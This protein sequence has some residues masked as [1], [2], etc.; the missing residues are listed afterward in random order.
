MSR[1]A[2]RLA[3]ASSDLSRDR[4]LVSETLGAAATVIHCSPLSE[5]RI[6]KNP[7]A[8]SRLREVLTVVSHQIGAFPHKTDFWDPRVG[9]SVILRPH[10][11]FFPN[12]GTPPLNGR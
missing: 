1:S 3:G 4:Q 5:N 6:S 12:Y 8:F 11:I 10:L 9:V 2:Q 7:A